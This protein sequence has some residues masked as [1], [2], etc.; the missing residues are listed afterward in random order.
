MR[1]LVL[2]YVKLRSSPCPKRSTNPALPGFEAMFLCSEFTC[3]SFQIIGIPM[4]NSYAMC[5][6]FDARYT[7]R[8]EDTATANARGNFAAKR[9][10]RIGEKEFIL[11]HKVTNPLN[12]FSILHCCETRTLYEEQR[13]SILLSY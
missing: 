5:F 4:A 9:A 12:R 6:T 10:S 13:N 1:R 8:D 2:R 3:S 11:R 7:Q